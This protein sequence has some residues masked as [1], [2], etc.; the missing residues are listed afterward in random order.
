MRLVLLLLL[1]QLPLRIRIGWAQHRL[2]NEE[3]VAEEGAFHHVSM[4]CM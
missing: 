2:L 3:C 4:W 1:L